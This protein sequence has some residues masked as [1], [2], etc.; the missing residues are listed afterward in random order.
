MSRNFGLAHIGAEGPGSD[1][2]GCFVALGYVLLAVAEL[3]A[4]AWLVTKGPW[5]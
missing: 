1:E 4:F 5:A 2:G 3:A